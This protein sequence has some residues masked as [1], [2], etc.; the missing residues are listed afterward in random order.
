MGG[1]ACTGDDAF[2]ATGLGA[3]GVVVKKLRGAVGADDFLFKGHAEV[4]QDLG[5]VLEGGPVG[6]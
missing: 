5:G 1:A 6:A 2:E 3:G 4:L